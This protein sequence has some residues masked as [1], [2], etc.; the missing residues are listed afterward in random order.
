MRFNLTQLPS[1]IINLDR[2]HDRWRRCSR[3]L[4]PLF[5]NDR[6]QRIAAIDGLKYI[7]ASENEEPTW[8]PRELLR[9]QYEGLV[10]RK[11]VL[12]PVRTA[13]CLSH[14]R[15]LHRFL[16]SGEP[17]GVIFEDDAQPGEALSELLAN[18]GL[19]EV[20]NDAE[21]LFLHD[22]VKSRGLADPHQGKS[23]ADSTKRVEW[24]V[25]RGGI[26]LEAYAVSISGARKMLAAW[27]PL[28]VECDVQLMTF[29]EGYVDAEARE[30]LHEQLRVEGGK[31]PQLLKAYAPRRPFFQVDSSNPSDKLQAIEDA[32]LFTYEIGRGTQ[33]VNGTHSR[34]AADAP[35]GRDPISKSR[36]FVPKFSFCITCKDRLEH[37]IQTLPKNL[38]VIRQ[39]GECEIVL[40]NYNS[41]DQMEEYVNTTCR[42]AMRLRLLRYARTRMPERY[43]TSHSKNLC[44]KA[45]KGEYLVNL[46]ADQFLNRPY[47]E[48]LCRA[49]QSGAD[50]CTFVYDAN[51]YGGGFGRINIKRDL[52]FKLG[53]YDE[54]HHG[55]GHED[56]DLVERAKRLGA[57]VK[58]ISS[59]T[60]EFIRHGDELRN[61][62]EADRGTEA[63]TWEKFF[64]AKWDRGDLIA[65]AGREW[66]VVPDLELQ[67][68]ALDLTVVI[69]NY[70]RTVNLPAIF[71]HIPAGAEI[72]LLDNAP[73]GWEAPDEIVKRAS[74]YVR[75]DGND[76]VLRWLLACRSQTRYFCVHDDDLCIKDWAPYLQK[77]VAVDTLVGPFGVVLNRNDPNKCYSRGIHSEESQMCDVIKG[78]A[79]FGRTDMLRR[80]F[81]MRSLDEI[82]I[83]NDDVFISSLFG[84]RHHL[85]G[86][87]GNILELA[88]NDAVSHRRQHLEKRDAFCKQHFFRRP[89]ATSTPKNTLADKP[90]SRGIVLCASP[91][92]VEMSMT[93]VASVRRSSPG[94]P[95]YCHPA[96]EGFASRLAKLSM[97][98]W[99]PF[100]ETLFIDC[101][102]VA[103]EPL[104]PVFDLLKSGSLFMAKET[105]KYTTLGNITRAAWLTESFGEE[106]TKELRKLPQDI[107]VWNSGVILF[108]KCK[109]THHFFQVW[110]DRWKLRGS[111]TL[112]QLPLAEIVNELGPPD[113]LP[114]YWHCQVS[115]Q[116][117]RAPIPQAALYHFMG[118]NKEEAML[119]WQ[120]SRP[121]IS[122]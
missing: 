112:D 96:D 83:S 113:E 14:Q 49:V 88:D 95:V 45:A 52:F 89:H 97:D 72:V 61:L 34:T 47:L 46:D 22:R 12:D 18:E 16:E 104:E 8:H 114:P 37:L 19:V 121:S 90:A 44:H 50:V 56:I 103:C 82:S 20:P 53:G 115:S 21:V 59:G 42:E 116:N 84:V 33:Y 86:V 108:K 23:G 13:L 98:L 43:N 93:A 80:R 24:R 109:A 66:G 75:S 30:R 99:S 36:E 48:E 122:D 63:A 17:W 117:P 65:N 91:A 25:A 55:Y 51:V 78:R 9:L 70:R 111:R 41:Q 5:G 15:A 69:V 7:A 31:R 10:G 29:I 1:W 35:C 105:P 118:I 73:P 4:V 58:T 81:E 107:P 38:E 101:D 100:D 68:G 39:H 79:V 3:T 28:L 11:R 110:R 106:Y 67:P 2:S 26:G 76:P 60:A 27:R 102:T 54:D 62:T 85:V 92:Y 40:L 6:C 120:K 57:R 64:R 32:K 119:R 71:D 94:L 77:I 87:P 74:W